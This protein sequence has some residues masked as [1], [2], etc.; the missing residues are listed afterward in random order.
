MQRGRPKKTDE[1]GEATCQTRRGW[2]IRVLI[3][4]PSA[5]R[6]VALAAP[7]GRSDARR[8][9]GQGR[10]DRIAALS[11]RRRRSTPAAAGAAGTS[12]PPN[13][14]RPRTSSANVRREHR[15][16]RT[17]RP[18]PRAG[19][20]DR[21]DAAAEGVV[22][23]LLALAEPYRRGWRCRS[24]LRVG[25][26]LLVR[27]ALEPGLAALPLALDPGVDLGLRRLRSRWAGRRRPVGRSALSRRSCSPAP[28]RVR[29]ISGPASV[30]PAS[31]IRGPAAG[32]VPGEVDPG[33]LAA[34]CSRRARPS[35][36]RARSPTACSRRTAP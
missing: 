32:S 22:Q 4:R 20:R 29:S 14:D 18:R 30:R 13:R 23:P 24:M 9:D 3:A 15:Y 2:R 28:A 11:R 35:P 36:C 34:G 27:R 26:A 16:S 8:R 21:A 17:P 31:G 19:P 12:P 6:G 5:H 7:E 25:V 10:A 33:R 1:G